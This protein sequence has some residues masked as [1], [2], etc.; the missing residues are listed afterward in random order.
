[1]PH[2]QPRNHGLPTD[3][4][5]NAFDCLANYVRVRF[6]TQHQINFVY[7]TPAYAQEALAILDSA[8][9]SDEHAAKEL[10]RADSVPNM[11]DFLR[12]FLPREQLEGAS[13]D[14]QI[15][16]SAAGLECRSLSGDWDQLQFDNVTNRSQLVFDPTGTDSADLSNPVA[17][18]YDRFWLE[19]G[20]VWETTAKVYEHDLPARLLGFEE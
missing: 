13:R 16:V 1:M 18:I 12:E 19:P 10:R 8:Y 15:R 6:A 4:S 5:P 17:N 2:K 11:L 9:E 7:T 14:A 3:G 20:T